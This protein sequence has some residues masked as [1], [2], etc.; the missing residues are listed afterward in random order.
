M[1][2][3]TFKLVL[4]GVPC[5]E[6]MTADDVTKLL[7]VIGIE[8]SEKIKSFVT[9]N[10]NSEIKFVIGS[11]G[12][13]EGVITTINGQA[14]IL[15]HGTNSQMLQAFRGPPSGS[16][17]GNGWEVDVDATRTLM[18]QPVNQDEWTYFYASRKR[19][20]NAIGEE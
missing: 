2:Q 18:G 4:N 11:D 17:P 8:M 10:G 3:P 7:S 12:N 13:F 15:I 16:N 9:S 1:A 19:I 6:C 14:V 5:L 20:L